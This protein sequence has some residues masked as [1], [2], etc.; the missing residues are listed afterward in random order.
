MSP[1][2]LLALALAVVLIIA[3]AS[4]AVTWLFLAAVFLATALVCVLFGQIL[5]A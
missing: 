3:G 4:L 5:A 1:W 2:T